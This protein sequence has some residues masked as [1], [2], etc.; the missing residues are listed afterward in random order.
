MRIQTLSPH[1]LH[2]PFQ[3]INYFL[4]HATAA[5]FVKAV[6]SPVSYSAIIIGAPN[7]SAIIIA[8]IHCWYGVTF[9]PSAVNNA[10]FSK[11]AIRGFMCFGA[12][13]GVVGNAIHGYA[14]NKSSI[15]WAIVGRFCLGFAATDIVQREV[16][17][18]CVPVHVVSE[19]GK[20]TLSGKIGSAV[21][22]VIGTL[23]ALPIAVQTIDIGRVYSPHTRQLQFS[24]WLMMTFWF[25]HLIRIILPHKLHNS[26]SNSV[27]NK[28]TNDIKNPS[29]VNLTEGTNGASDSES[30]SSAVIGTPSS[31]MLRPPMDLIEPI[32]NSSTNFERLTEK[33]KINSSLSL[34]HRLDEDVRDIRR[35]QRISRPWKT[36]RRFRK[37]L[38]FHVGVPITL[39]LYFYTSFATEVFCTATPFITDR[40]FA[41]SGARA[42]TFLGCLLLAAL[43]VT[44]V[45]EIVARR[46]EERAVIKVCYHRSGSL[47]IENI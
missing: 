26:H 39:L 2:C 20:L 38:A 46:Y 47:D 22:C 23:S 8:M 36:V 9:E 44:V 7:V 1:Y 34:S 19:S 35:S 31:V 42:G 43:P 25:C 21:G 10:R 29:T 16:M 13:M 18:M 45:C 33:E 41:W 40:Y 15:F 37:L 5:T 32:T 24:S 6:G 11:N 12:V 28:A 3:K 4:S 27:L 17:S 30:S 14:I